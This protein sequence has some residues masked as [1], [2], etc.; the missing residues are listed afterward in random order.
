MSTSLPKPRLGS[1]G[2]GACELRAE[3][4][5]HALRGAGDGGAEVGACFAERKP[6]ARSKLDPDMADHGAVRVHG[7]PEPYVRDHYLA[8]VGS[9]LRPEALLDETA[10]ELVDELHALAVY[11]NPKCGRAFV[12]SQSRAAAS[13]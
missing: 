5:S 13:G 12:G 4:D 9:E 7:H 3:S 10:Q 1:R 2:F 11:R 8:R 6:A